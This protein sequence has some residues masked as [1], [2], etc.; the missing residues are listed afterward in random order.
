MTESKQQQMH[1]IVTGRVQG[2]G[3]R[4]YV[5]R[6]ARRVGL[7]GYVRNNRDQTV[8]VVAEGTTVALIALIELLR[9][10]P[11]E[12]VVRSVETTF[13]EASGRYTHFTINL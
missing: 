5:L 11:S 4:Q 8:E 6:H 1:A 12:A 10:G 9:E 2:V 7:V 3:Y 13:S